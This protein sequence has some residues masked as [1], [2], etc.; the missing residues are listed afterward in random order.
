MPRLERPGGIQLHWEERG[1][2]PLV[3]I[4]PHWSGVPEVFE[5]LIGDLHLDHRVMTYDARG[6]GQSS[7]SGPHDMETGAGDLEAVI[8]TAGEQAI[9][10][11]ISDAPNHG[12][13][14][15]A[16]RPDLAVA[17]IALASAPFGQRAI[18]ET[19]SLIASE[20]VVSA[21]IEQIE[22]DYRG[23][24]RSMLTAANPQLDEAGVRERV[25][26]QVEY[27]PR[28][29]G[30][31]RLRAWASDDAIEEGRAVGERYWMLYSADTAGPWFPSISEMLKLMGRLLPDAHT[32]E[33]ANGIV[34]RPDVTAEVVRRITATSRSAV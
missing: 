26:R 32:E 33:I 18:R 9:V 28:E 31:E 23:A 29:V 20:T 5:P 1:E 7:R 24:L 22:T 17:V 19:E 16:R 2:G 25:A 10:V 4:A 6:T 11:G 13:R 34:S 30:V 8:E 21:F 12:V 3:V 27:C 14:V 15:A